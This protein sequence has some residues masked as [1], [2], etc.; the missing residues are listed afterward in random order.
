MRLCGRSRRH[1]SASWERSSRTPGQFGRRRHLPSSRRSV[2]GGFAATVAGRLDFLVSATASLFLPV[3]VFCCEP[4]T[5]LPSIGV[6]L[7][8]TVSPFGST[9]PFFP[10]APSPLSSGV[11]FLVRAASVW[12]STEVFLSAG[13]GCPARSLA[14]AATTDCLFAGRFAW[15]P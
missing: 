3:S 4:S 11:A 2:R 7:A 8:V 6:F 5:I 12:F 13:L 14:L 1:G 9:G 10:F 15:G